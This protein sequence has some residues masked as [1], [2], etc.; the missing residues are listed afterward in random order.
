[1]SKT[2][3]RYARPHIGYWETSWIIYFLKADLNLTIIKLTSQNH[4]SKISFPALFV[5]RFT[6]N[7]N[8]K[9]FES[10]TMK[11]VIELAHKIAWSIR[12]RNIILEYNPNRGGNVTANSSWKESLSQAAIDLDH[13]SIPAIELYSGEALVASYFAKWSSLEPDSIGI[14]SQILE[15][16]NQMNEENLGYDQIVLL[17]AIIRKL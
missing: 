9:L 16:C 4:T 7:Q 17:G 3:I 5:P 10:E 6:N 14:N 2:Y 13:D 1:M 12:N 8:L 15:K 11:R